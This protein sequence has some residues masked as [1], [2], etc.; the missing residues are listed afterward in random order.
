[1]QQLYA[2]VEQLI[3]ENASDFKI[4]QLIKQ[5][6]SIYFETL[7]DTFSKR[8]GK[9]FLTKHTR[10]I[11][12]VVKLVYQ[13]TMRSM[14]GDYL[15]LKNSIPIT[16]A[17]L[18]SYG[19]EQLCVHSDIDLM[20]VYKETQAYHTKEL[21]E[22]M[23]Y[24]FWDI[25]LKLGHRV[26]EVSELA[27]V[28]QSD[29]TIKSAMLESRF[30]EGSRF[31]WTEAENK[32]AI[33]RK[34]DPKKFIREKLE[35]QRTLHHK[36]PLTMEPN[37]KEG[38]GGFRDANLIFWIGKLL[39][40]VPRIKDLPTNIVDD[41]DYR[42][43]RIALEFIF[44]TRS[45]LHLVA[46]K[47]EDR[48]RLEY[49]PDVS[50]LLG[51]QSTNA[52]QM[53]FAKKCTE[54][55][56]YINLFGRIWLNRLIHDYLPN[57][58]DE[59]LLFD[60]KDKNLI[61]LIG[62]LN[63][64]ASCL[65]KAHPKILSGLLHA[66]RTDRPDEKIY[67]AINKIFEQESAF[68]V[69]KTL[70]DARL[71]TYCIPV[72]KKVIDLPQFDGYHNYSVG[73]H[74][75][76]TLYHLENIKD[77]LLQEIYEGLSSD[78]KHL[79]KLVVFL[80]DVGKGRKRDHSLVGVSL[81]RLFAI[82][83]KLD[84]ELT[85]IG[86]ILIRHH[87]LMSFTA[88]REDLYNE[89]TIFQFAS[90]LNSKLLLDLMYLLTYADMNG[91]GDDIYT[92]FNAGLIL[93][94]Y[95]EAVESL[96]HDEILDIV[97][98]RV[99]KIESLKRNSLFLQ[100]SKPVQ[101]KIVSI[102][103][104]EFFIKNSN[105]KI[106]SISQTAIGIDEFDYKI[107][108]NSFLTI[109]IIRKKHVAL[110][111]LL[112]K[113]SRIHIVSMEITKL[114]D[115]LKYFKINFSEKIDDAE[116][117]LVKDIICKSFGSNPYA[118]Y[119]KPSIKAEEISINCEHSRDYATMKIQTMNQKGLLAYITYLFDELSIDI[120]SAKVHT[121]KRRVNDLFLIE[122]DGSFCDNTDIIMKKLTE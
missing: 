17:A 84:K 27:N 4:A 22:K 19:R 69:L 20:I 16:L 103:S 97:A 113:L 68:S 42:Q 72:F 1:M 64:N 36:Y 118:T 92:N 122:K 115:G 95:K 75:L 105:K 62:D 52:D 85:D 21:I 89:K 107:S 116:T 51:Y 61:Q 73:V 15:P 117:D 108:N 35:E 77:P 33:M 99:K 12:T 18:G 11:D 50:R 82:N 98:R 114:F 109:E 43:F 63:R 47:K 88:Q 57:A 111:Y 38:Y 119:I 8:S 39:Y 56:R 76:Q 106:V 58:Y 60:V 48:L 90:Q 46:G 101:K 80:H 93:T 81:F 104:N 44:R 78:H 23:L 100:L 55:L 31:L 71:L 10:K 74:S 3:S 37:L 59:Y 67:E 26:H 66:R 86:E 87:N 79:L 41:E 112:S 83:I 110:G 7:P 28:A 32:I 94:L 102:P 91:V 65:Y 29:V 70:F 53:R 120:T 34:N 30:I 2:Q 121:S 9:D 49:I 96:K 14:F 45:A 5:D 24:M 54:S 13:I 40:N 6:I 25:G